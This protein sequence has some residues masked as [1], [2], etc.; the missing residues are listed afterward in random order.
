MTQDHPSS[1]HDALISDVVNALDQ[2]QVPP[3]PDV[4][5]T[6]AQ[7]TA[8]APPPEETTPPKNHPWSFIMRQYR[9]F[10]AAAAIIVAVSAFFLVSPGFD[11][12][13]AFAQAAQHLR[14][15]KTLAFTMT[16]AVPGVGGN[17]EMKVSIKNPG[18]MAIESEQAGQSF[19]QVFDF[20]SQ[21][22]VML[23]PDQKFAQRVNIAGMPRGQNPNDIIAEFSRI[24]P[25]HATYLQDEEKDGVACHAYAVG[26]GPIQGK[27]WIAVDSQ[28]TVRFEFDTMPGM[29]NA[30]GGGPAATM[31]NFQWDAVLDD[32][33]F[34]LDIPE[35]YEV[36][37]ID[38]SGATA[39]DLA[40]MLRLYAAVTAKPFPDDFRLETMT[41]VHTV[42]Q[43]PEL[44]P[45]DNHAR[46]IERLTPIYGKEALAPEKLEQTL[47][48]RFSADFGRGAIFLGTISQEA[49]AWHWAGG[50][51]SPGDGSQ[52]LCW[53]KPKDSPTYHVIYNDFSIKQVTQDQLPSKSQ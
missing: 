44:S 30:A 50:G 34:T 46:L 5:H 51:V 24:A 13:V 47:G 31:R 16:A 12:N 35:G 48:E 28:R 6:V 9:P 1:E 37:E 8:P 29:E 45:Q 49:Q 10:A 21:Q 43:D 4:E 22:M 14:A 38:M 23:M 52:A 33:K 2:V 53:W 20:A 36:R 27:T 3:M 7:L 41:T 26:A 18:W 15:A 40:Q 42:M 39:Q 25:E 17:I 11:S 19:T 32:A